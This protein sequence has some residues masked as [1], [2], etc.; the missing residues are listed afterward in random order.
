MSGTCCLVKNCSRRNITAARLLKTS[1][2]NF[3]V[4]KSERS[5]SEKRVKGRKAVEGVEAS[6]EFEA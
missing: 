6:Y 5:T 2:I 1:I 3:N 4:I